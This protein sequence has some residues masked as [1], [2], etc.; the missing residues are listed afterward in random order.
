M[1]QAE[2]VINEVKHPLLTGKFED[3]YAHIELTDEERDTALRYARQKKG[4]AIREREY[5]DKVNAP[6]SYPDFTAEEYGEFVMKRIK[7]ISPN[8]VIDKWNKKI[9][10]ILCFYF[11]G[12]NCFEDLGFSFEKG[13]AIQGPIGCGKTTLL[14][15]F[16]INPTNS[17][18]TVHCRAVADEYTHKEFGGQPI[19]IKY[20]QLVTVQPKEYWGQ[21]RVGRFFDDL[22]TEDISKHF[23]NSKNVMEAIIEYRYFNQE[24]KAKTHITT[25]LSAEQIEEIYGQRVRSRCREMFNFLTFDPAAPDRSI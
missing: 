7:G 11:T 23:G 24:L 21:D 18:T 16:N 13:I 12:D 22:G 15:A 19:V 9:F 20:S 1:S 6:V 5:W 25:N 8:F 2:K 3:P 10:S 17:Y 4:V 14:R